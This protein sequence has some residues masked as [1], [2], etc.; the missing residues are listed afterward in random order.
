MKTNTFK[1]S[2]LKTGFFA[3][4][5]VAS[6]SFSSCK[7]EEKPVDTEE[8]ATE[9]N[10]EKFDDTKVEDDAEFL[11]AASEIN[12]NEIALGKLAQTKGTLS[13]VKDLGKMMETEHT[14]ALKELQDLAAKKQI[15]IPASATEDGQKEYDDL[16]KKS[17]NDFDKAYADMMVSGH[18]D[19]IDKFEKAAS[20]SVDPEVKAWAAKML[21]ALNTH[22]GHADAV[23]IKTDKLK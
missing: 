3:T 4:L 23:K 13:D 1:F 17:G 11:V 19:A 7:K 20:S 12:M 14:A 8:V 9:Q 21:P 15:S 10:D 5:L 16:N 6:L 2:I 18:K 22:K